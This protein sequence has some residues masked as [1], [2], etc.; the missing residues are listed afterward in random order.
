[1]RPLTVRSPVTSKARTGSVLPFTSSRPRSR[2]SKKPA[3]RRCVV[4]EI[5]TVP[6]AASASTG[7]AVDPIADHFLP[8][9][10]VLSF[11]TAGCNLGCKLCGR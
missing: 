10:R 9:A 5:R 3:T 6:G 11:G 2:V 4:S 7:F 1:M 8:G